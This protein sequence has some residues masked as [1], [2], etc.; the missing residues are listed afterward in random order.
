M[1]GGTLVVVS[2]LVAC[3]NRPPGLDGSSVETLPDRELDP[4]PSETPVDGPLDPAALPAGSQPCREAIEVVVTSVTDGDTV[5]VQLVAGGWA[6]D[7]RLIGL[8]TPELGYAGAPDDCGATQAR[9]F[10][11]SLVRG[12]TGWLTF[13]AECED[14][15]GRSLAYLHT[16]DQ[17][18]GFVNRR[19]VADGYAEVMTIDPN[20]TFA[21]E[22]AALEADAREAERGI[23][24]ECR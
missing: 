12:S 19:L 22:F 21:A 10:L 9:D 14:D 6:E 1:R 17:N 2:L 7:V 20:N 16:S 11:E 23:W 18:E 3:M 4:G 8:D 5:E 24:S 15:Y 13:D